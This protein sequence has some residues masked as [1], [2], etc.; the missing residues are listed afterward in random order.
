MLRNGTTLTARLLFGFHGR[1]EFGSSLRAVELRTG[2][3]RWSQDR[4]A[5]GSVILAGAGLSCAAPL[6]ALLS[7]GPDIRGRM[8]EDIPR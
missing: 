3:V 1:Q 2:A 8:R 4:F 7:A 5:A 6:T